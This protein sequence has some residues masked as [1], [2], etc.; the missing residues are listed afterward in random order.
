MFGIKDLELNY[1]YWFGS[2]IWR[3]LKIKIENRIK[4]HRFSLVWL[5]A[6]SVDLH[7]GRRTVFHVLV[8][9]QTR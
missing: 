2:S 7:L 3:F 5:I 1:I 4:P 6:Q 8:Y 9:Y